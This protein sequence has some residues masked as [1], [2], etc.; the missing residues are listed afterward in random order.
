MEMIKNRETIT[1]G[2]EENPR[3]VQTID[4]MDTILPSQPEARS[5]RYQQRIPRYATIVELGSGQFGTV[6][7]AVDVDTGEL[8]AVKRLRR[9]FEISGPFSEP[10]PYDTLK[11]EVEILSRLEHVSK[12]TLQL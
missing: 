1:F 9:S 12:I 4:W 8:L 10:R 3:F 11:R 6:W 5:L 2:Y 7:K